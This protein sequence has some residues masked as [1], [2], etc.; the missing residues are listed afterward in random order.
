MLQGGRNTANKY[1]WRV[2]GAAC[3]GSARSVW[4][5]LGLPPL[6]AFPVSTAQAPGCSAGGLSKA[7]FGLCA[8]PR[9]KL[10]RFRFSGSSQRYRLIWVCVLCPS[11]VWEAQVT[12]C[13]ASAHSPGGGASFH[14]PG[15]RCSVSWVR[16]GSSASGV[17][18]VSSGELIFGCDPPGGRQASRIP[19]RLGYQLGACSQ[20]GRGCH[21]WGQVCPLPSGSGCLPP[22]SLTLAG[23]GLVCC[24]LALLRYSLSP[25]FCERPGNA[26][27]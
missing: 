10:L 7:G 26:L 22:A 5:T 15:P 27:G 18:C 8:L 17:L 3:V 4:A 2:W 16:R 20:F 6:T 13:L 14:L 25:L 1:H 21:L 12:R 19:G 9:S 11:Q 23:D 24:W